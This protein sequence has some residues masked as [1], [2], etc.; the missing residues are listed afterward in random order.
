M[1]AA[2]ASPSRLLTFLAFDFG[3]RR[4]GV[5]SGN[6]LTRT[7]TPLT[8]IEASGDALLVAI[9]RLVDEWRPAALVVGVPLHPDGA[10]HVNTRR[11]RRFAR[12]LAERF[13]LPVHEVD[14]RYSSLE[15]RGSGGEAG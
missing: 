5:A 4:T 6:A 3:T 8:T 11:A 13:G 7:A 9:T 12:Q 2:P 15:A 10:A 14:E 1:I